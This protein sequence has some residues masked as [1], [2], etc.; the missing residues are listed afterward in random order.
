[1]SVAMTEAPS[2]TT[3]AEPSVRDADALPGVGEYVTVLAAGAGG[4]G[5]ATRGHWIGTVGEVLPGAPQAGVRLLLDDGSLVERTTS[6]DAITVDLG[7]PCPEGPLGKAMHAL[8]DVCTAM[9]RQRER[10][11]AWRRDFAEEA[12]TRADSMSLCSEFDEFMEYWGLEGRQREFL[13]RVSVDATV[14]V[15]ITARNLGDAESM[16]DSDM[17]REACRETHFNYEVLETEAR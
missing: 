7:V 13:C 10:H 1:M 5:A 15:P 6:P 9:D 16:I 12:G 11:E 8:A 2:T 3:G 14:W 4:Y 17:V